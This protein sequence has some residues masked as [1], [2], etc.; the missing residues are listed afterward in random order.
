[1]TWPLLGLNAA[2]HAWLRILLH[3]VAAVTV[4]RIARRASLAPP[5]QLIAG[6]LFAATP[7]VF[8]PLYWASGIQELLGGTLA[9]L[10][11]E[12]WLAG[13]RVGVLAAGLLGAGS[14]LAKESAL[15]LPLVFV[16]TLVPRWSARRDRNLFRWP[17]AMLLAAVSVFESSL[18]L[19]HFATGP[20]DPYALGGPLVM[21]GNLGKFGWWLPTPGPV[22]T[23][24]V[25]WAKAGVGIAF[26]LAWAVGGAWAWRRGKRLPLVAWACALLS[27]GPALPLVNQARPYMAYLAAA[28]GSLALAGLVP[29]R[30]VRRAGIVVALAVVAIIWGQVTMR[31]RMGRLEADKLPADP[32]VRATQTARETAREILE[33]LPPRSRDEAFS[34]VIFQPQLTSTGGSDLLSQDQP[35]VESRRYSALSGSLGVGLLLG[36]SA[37]ARWTSSLLESPA[38]AFVVC[39]KSNGFQAWGSTYDA[40]L[41]AAELHVVQRNFQLAVDHLARASVLRGAR[42][43]RIP[44]EDVLGFPRT[45]LA[46]PA[47]EFDRWLAA[48]VVGRKMSSVEYDRYRGFF[49]AR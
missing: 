34:L 13:G 41:Y 37:H 3:A 15:A 43:L 46:K 35:S 12:R 28:A 17:V 36:P 42:E 23:A 9:L 31:E 48:M 14:I 2:G 22:F 38:D 29:L 26:L 6:L 30:W 8:T 5:A 32:I 4:V 27:V 7:I 24:Q 1:M 40:L 20:R 45:A 25:T 11:I 39:E 19:K 33:L 10:A 49:G 18:I 16:A 47:G 21:L 44:A